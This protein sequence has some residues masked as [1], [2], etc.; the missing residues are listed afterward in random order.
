MYSSTERFYDGWWKVREALGSQRYHYVSLGVGTGKKDSLI[1]RDLHKRD[2]DMSYFPID[3]SPEMLRLGTRRAN[4]NGRVKRH[5][6]WPIQIDF[7]LDSNVAALRD[8]LDKRVGGEPILFS[9]LG[10]TLAN[11]E[12]DLE[13]LKT[14]SALIGPDD[15]LLL[16]VART[17][18]LDDRACQAAAIEYLNNPSFRE[19]ATSA[20][21]QNTDLHIGDLRDVHCATDVEPDKAIVIKTFHRSQS[22]TTITLPDRSPVEYRAEDTIRLYL[23]RKYTA[24]GIADLLGACGFPVLSEHASFFPDSRFGFGMNLLLLGAPARR[25]ASAPTPTVFISYSHA[26]AE[27]ARR[28]HAGL[29]AAG[30]RCWLDT[31]DM[32]AGDPIRP[33]LSKNIKA[34]EKILVI[35]SESALTSR[36]VMEELDVMFDLEIDSGK[37]MVIPLRLDDAVMS[38]PGEIAERLRRRGIADFRQRETEADYQRAFDKLLHD[39]KT[40]A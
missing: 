22:D 8:I 16:E 26:D 3:M 19:F 29:T 4:E 38:A 9:L 34:H 7:A 1:L 31:I 5:N 6:V 25:P 12:E 33:T 2:P 23:S 30:V 13:L 39:L 10:N 14:L 21:L 27:F 24:K 17:E 28:L 40:G 35:M 15:R 11:F 37:R 32:R 36:W 20:L 18:Q